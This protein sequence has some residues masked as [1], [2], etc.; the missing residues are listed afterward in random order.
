MLA[1]LDPCIA[2]LR[3]VATAADVSTGMVL[4]LYPSDDDD[5][6]SDDDYASSLTGSSDEAEGLDDSSSG[7]QGADRPA[8]ARHEEPFAR[9]VG[10]AQQAPAA[11]Q[12][13]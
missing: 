3:E 5:P 2:R 10:N 6:G 7:G 13:T 11:T 4:G 12:Q 9:V 1:E 8:A